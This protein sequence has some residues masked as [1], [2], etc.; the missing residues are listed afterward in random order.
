VRLGR[1]GHG[2]TFGH[3]ALNLRVIAMAGHGIPRT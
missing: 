1:F 3:Q 2:A